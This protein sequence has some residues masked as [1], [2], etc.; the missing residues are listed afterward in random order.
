[1]GQYLSDE[2]DSVVA[3]VERRY[4]PWLA[5]L[6]SVN[7]RAV[8]AQYEATIP[9]KYLPAIVAATCYMRTLTNIQAAV[10]MLLRGA[11]APARVLLRASMESLFKLKAIERDPNIVNAIIAGCVCWCSTPG[12][13][14]EA[15]ALDPTS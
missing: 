1:M 9:R 14:H 10:V 13:V 8:E 15:R 7:K 5:L 4:A 2:V 11:E 12:R 6:R 3:V